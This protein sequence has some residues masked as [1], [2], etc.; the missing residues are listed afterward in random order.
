MMVIALTGGAH[1]Q[2]L[3]LV[4]ELVKASDRRW[5]LQQLDHYNLTPDARYASLARLYLQARNREL[6]T[7]VTGVNTQ[8]EYDKLKKNNALICVLPGALSAI[9]TTGGASLD[10]RICYI[11]AKKFPVKEPTKRSQ[12]ITAEDALSLCYARDRRFRGAF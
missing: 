10:N 8:A 4:D 7:I 1:A 6:I 5:T 2:Q 9:F 3:A 11:A 12:Y